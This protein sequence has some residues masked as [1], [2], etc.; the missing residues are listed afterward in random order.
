[1]TS[2]VKNWERATYHLWE[3]LESIE[4][5]TRRSKKN[6]RQIK[7]MIEKLNAERWD[8]LN[9]EE[10]DDLYAK[11]SDETEYFNSEDE[12]SIFKETRKFDEE[13]HE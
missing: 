4:S 7:E 2:K 1:M 3:I 13:N 6:H 12:Q 5:E 10:V 8:V 9:L 11:F